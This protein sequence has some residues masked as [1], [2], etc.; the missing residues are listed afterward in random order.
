M[1]MLRDLRVLPWGNERFRSSFFE[2]RVDA[3]PVVGSIERSKSNGF[4][5]LFEQWRNMLRIFGE[6]DYPRRT[7]NGVS[8]FSRHAN[9]SLSKSS[10]S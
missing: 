8:S 6:N 2:E 9:S 3:V 5:D 4:V 10:S 7:E 1:A